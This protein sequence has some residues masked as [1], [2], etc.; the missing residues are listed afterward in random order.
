M[1]ESQKDPVCGREVSSLA[2]TAVFLGV[3]YGFCSLECRDRFLAYPD[4]YAGLRGQRSPRRQG[5]RRSAEED[6]GDGA[7]GGEAGNRDCRSSLE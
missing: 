2:I 3:E 7:D 5:L 6:A 4:L 1:G